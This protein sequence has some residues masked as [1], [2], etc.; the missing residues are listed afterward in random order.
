MPSGKAI[1]EGLARSR[2][3]PLTEY[4]LYGIMNG[5][6]ELRW[7]EEFGQWIVSQ[8]V[9]AAA[10]EDIRAGLLILRELGP[11]LG[12]PHVDTLQGSKHSNMKELRVQSKGR[13]FRIFFAFDPKRR[14]VLLIGGN[15]QGKKRFYNVHLPIA[16]QLFDAYLKEL[17]HE[18]R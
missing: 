3:M 10:R 5:M 8:E 7:T 4:A 17:D 6:W 11:A 9:D 2:G 18:K 15:K 12:R 1:A 14:A 13:P 16:D